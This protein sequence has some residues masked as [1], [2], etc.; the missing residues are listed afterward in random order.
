MWKNLKAT[1][2]MIQFIWKIQQNGQI[3]WD[4]KLI[5]GSLGQE[6]EEGGSLAVWDSLLR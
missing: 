1:G 6:R 4:K 3:L 2:C 5:S